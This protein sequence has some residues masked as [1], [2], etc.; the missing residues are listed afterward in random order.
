MVPDIMGVDDHK[1]GV[2][3]QLLQR[4]CG[5]QVGT[6]SLLAISCAKV[7]TSF[8]NLMANFIP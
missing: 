2:L 7:W 4:G 8:H 3:S 1:S 5:A 6:D